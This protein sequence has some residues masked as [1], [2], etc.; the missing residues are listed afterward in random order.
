VP[1]LILGSGLVRSGGDHGEIVARS[2]A[3]CYETGA[4]S[5]RGFGLFYSGAGHCRAKRSPTGAVA[6]WPVSAIEF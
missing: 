6:A 3:G 2:R 5:Y 4:I 1:V